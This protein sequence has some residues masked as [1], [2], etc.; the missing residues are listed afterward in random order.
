MHF[1]VLFWVYPVRPAGTPRWGDSS[2]IQKWSFWPFRR[3]TGSRSVTTPSAICFS[4]RSKQDPSVLD[5][6]ALDGAADRSGLIFG[7]PTALLAYVT[8][9]CLS[10]LMT[11]SVFI[12]NHMG[13]R[14]LEDEHDVA[15]SNSRPRPA[16]T[17]P[18]G[19]CSTS[20]TGGSTLRFD[21]ISSRG[22]PTTVIA[23][24]APSSG[25]IF[26]EPGVS[27]SGGHA[28]RRAGLGREP[29]RRHDRRLCQREAGRC[30][31]ASSSGTEMTATPM[32]ASDS[33]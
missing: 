33:P 12:P 9:S 16:E 26:N 27:L 24:C 31:S 21:T 10:S 17:S 15:T 14:R 25:P 2:E 11:V 4:D 22:W 23:R 20:I 13:M 5:A 3:S 32:A 28:L 8:V 1:G 6:T 30:S 7:W 18:I 29:P 19:R